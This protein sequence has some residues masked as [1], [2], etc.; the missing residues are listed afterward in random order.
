[1][2]QAQLYDHAQP[3]RHVPASRLKRL[4]QRMLAVCVAFAKGEQRLLPFLFTYVFLCLVV[5]PLFLFSM[6][7]AVSVLSDAQIFTGLLCLIACL[8]C[9]LVR[10]FWRVASHPSYSRW[11]F[12]VMRYFS[13]VVLLNTF[14]VIVQSVGVLLNLTDP[15]ASPEVRQTFENLLSKMDIKH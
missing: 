10:G 12:Y 1:M 14:P 6:R 9:V 11:V 8:Q 3:H 5:F 4:C 13:V 7:R 15:L 2:S